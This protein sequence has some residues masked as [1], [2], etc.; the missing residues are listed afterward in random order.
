LT[1]EIFFLLAPAKFSFWKKEKVLC[2]LCE[3]VVVKMKIAS[4]VGTRPNFIK[5]APLSK[6]LRKE[7]DEV[8]I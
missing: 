4:V 7:F 2:N 8:I 6:G 1:K 5:C 3:S